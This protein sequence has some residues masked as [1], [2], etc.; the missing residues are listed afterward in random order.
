MKITTEE[1]I[2]EAL[3]VA[4]IT[5]DNDCFYEISSSSF[6]K[7]L[8]LP[9][10]R[11]RIQKYKIEGETRASYICGIKKIN[12]KNL[13]YTDRYTGCTERVIWGKDLIGAIWLCCNK[14]SIL[15]E[16]RISNSVALYKELFER[17]KGI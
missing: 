7:A 14:F 10:F 15:E 4:G 5:I 11:F 1:Q 2:Q 16:L 13:N 12:K 8:E 9:E 17:L 3:K 6:G